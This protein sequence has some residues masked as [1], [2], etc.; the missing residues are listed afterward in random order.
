MPSFELA[1]QYV[2]GLIKECYVPDE[3]GEALRTLVRHR[4]DLGHKLTRTKN[5][6]HSQLAK[7]G[8]HH[9]YPRD[10]RH[11]M[12]PPVNPRPSSRVALSQPAA[13]VEEMRWSHQ[14]ADCPA[15]TFMLEVSIA[16][17]LSMPFGHASTLHLR[18]ITPWRLTCSV[19]TYRR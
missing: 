2:L 3:E 10:K 18:H 12:E 4:I 19:T 5:Q 16:M 14:P 6:I 1:K 17:A 9:D 13:A 7:S 11:R 8:I 15:G